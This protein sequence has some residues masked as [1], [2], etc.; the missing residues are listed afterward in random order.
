M[1]F[2]DCRGSGV[3]TG[4]FHPSPSAN[5]V[6]RQQD[7]LVAKENQAFLQ[8]VRAVNPFGILANAYQNN[9]YAAERSRS[10]NHVS[11]LDVGSRST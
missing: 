8:L 5:L 2:S 4:I 7:G 9:Q 10:I 1:Q 3:F 11:T 6:G